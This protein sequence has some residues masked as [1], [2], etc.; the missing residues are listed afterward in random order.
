VWFTLAAAQGEKDAIDLRD[1][2]AKK[3][4]PAQMEGAQKLAREW[5]LTDK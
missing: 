1:I 2:V 5:K 4:T 3:M